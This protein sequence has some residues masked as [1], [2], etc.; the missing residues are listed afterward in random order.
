MEYS[1]MSFLL[2]YLRD[3]D[4][5][6]DVGANIGAYSVL[7]GKICK[8]GYAFEPSVDTY[9]ICCENLKLN[10]FKN[11]KLNCLGV[12]NS[13]EKVLFTKGLDATNH[14]I[15]D[16]QSIESDD[17][18]KIQIVSL[19]EFLKHE[20]EISIIKIDVE[21]LEEQV[22][23]GAKN[24]LNQSNLNIV[25]MEV[26]ENEK[27]VDLMKQYGFKAYMYDADKHVLH[28]L[29]YM[30]DKLGDNCIFIK[31]IGIVEKR[32]IKYMC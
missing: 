30:H 16:K 8:R 28:T 21:G 22:L 1:E 4:V 26:F 19:D 11:V 3:E 32:G 14:V 25:I 23:D 24:L 6:V 17:V 27:L 29:K 31:D 5:F 20:K 10:N 13:N 9:K 2:D 18:E 7:L 12:G 15:N